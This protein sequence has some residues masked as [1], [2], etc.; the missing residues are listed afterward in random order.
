MIEVFVIMSIMV[1]M[2]VY[3]NDGGRHDTELVL[4]VRMV[5]EMLMFITVVI[6]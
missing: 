4:A 5:V 3:N 1:M 6:M 2:T